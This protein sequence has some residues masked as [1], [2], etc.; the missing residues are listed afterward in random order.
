MLAVAASALSSGTRAVATLA[1][2]AVLVARTHASIHAAAERALAAP[3]TRTAVG[4]AAVIA[5]PRILAEQRTD[6]QSSLM[7]TV[8]GAQLTPSPYALRNTQR[9]TLSAARP[10]D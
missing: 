10:C 6:R 1:D 4:T 5:G 7:V 2:D 9:L 3:C 8:V